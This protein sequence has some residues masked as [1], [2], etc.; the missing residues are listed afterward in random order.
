MHR[1]LDLRRRAGVEGR[2]AQRAPPGRY[3]PCRCSSSRS[4]PARPDRR[5]SARC[6]APARPGGSRRA[7]CRRCCRRPRRRP[8]RAGR[9]LAIWSISASRRSRSSISRNSMS[10]SSVDRVRR[11]SEVRRTRSIPVSAIL[12]RFSAIAASTWPSLP[13]SRASSRCGVST[14]VSW[15]RPWASSVSWPSISRLSRS[16]CDCVSRPAAP[17]AR[18]SAWR[19]GSRA[20]SSW[21]FSSF[22]TLRRASNCCCWAAISSAISGSSAAR[23][24]S[25][26]SKSIAS[27]RSRSAESRLLRARISNH[28]PST[29]S[30]SERSASPSSSTSTSPASTTSPSRTWIASITPPVRCWTTWRL[31]STSTTPGAITAPEMRAIAPQSP[32]PER[33]QD[34]RGVAEHQEGPHVPAVVDGSSVMPGPPRDAAGDGR[35]VAHMRLQHLVARTEGLGGRRRR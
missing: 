7:G 35:V 14:R 20:R 22:C 13:L 4:G 31:P 28:W 32:M 15:V 12:P 26:G 34:Q 19:S 23:S 25:S 27:A 5:P 8:A 24:R 1:A 21:S 2:E 30:S 29:I 11:V 16:I 18:R 33:R 6:R 3:G 10:R 17:R 9:S